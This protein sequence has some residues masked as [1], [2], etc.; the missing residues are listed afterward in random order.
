MPDLLQTRRFGRDARWLKSAGST[1]AEALGW[2]AEGV[3]EGALV[4]TDHQ[5]AGRGRQG[6]EWRDSPGHN[7]LFS[8][9]LRPSIPTNRIGLIPLAAGL[10]VAEAIE[11]QTGLSPILKWPN[12]VLLADRK[13]CGVLL[14]GQFQTRSASDNLMVLGIGLNVNQVDFDPAIAG[15]ATSLSLESGQIVPRQPL[16]AEL[17]HRLEKHY[18]S[19]PLDN[20][21]SV[22]A[23]FEKRMAGIG[24]MVSVAFSYSENSIAGTV[25]GVAD[26]GALRLRTSEGVEILHA[27]EIT[28]AT[29]NPLVS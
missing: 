23:H 2:A 6:R 9:V 18:E 8:I 14:E 1:N 21:A 10:A 27:G 15:N 11:Q 5:T 19:L 12:D 4:G 29:A 22:R 24:R 13:V 26:D 7:L 17:L 25:L 20:G 28:L 3:P 16:L